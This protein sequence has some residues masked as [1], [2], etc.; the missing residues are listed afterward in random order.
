[1]RKR[2]LVIGSIVIAIIILTLVGLKTP[3]P[4]RK[5]QSGSEDR[6]FLIYE[7]ASEKLASGDE[8]GAIRD[9]EKL[10]ENYADSDIAEK[11]LYELA[12]IAEKQRE[13]LKARGLYQ[14]GLERFL[15]SSSAEKGQKKLEELNIEI[16]FS[17]IE[18]PGSFVYEVKRGDTL[19][20]LA[21]RFDTTVEFIMKTNNLKSSTIKVGKQ[22]KINKLK[23]SIVVD[24]S[25]NL[26]TLKGDGEVLKSYRVSTGVDNSTPTGT[27]KIITKVIEPTWY[28]EGAVVPP[29]SPKNILGSRWLGMSKPGYGIHGSR[30]PNSIGRQITAGC[31]RMMNEDVDELYAIVPIGTEVVI[32]N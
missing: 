15:G 28:S 13:L 2:I 9:Y 25:L 17:P 10:V 4:S 23:I 32:V 27:F 31:I 26:L 12:S 1:M 21:K 7:Q 20:K 29:G 6:A 18:S 14:K 3:T 8:D 16:L 19:G 11:A 5:S 22:L 24:K 30:D